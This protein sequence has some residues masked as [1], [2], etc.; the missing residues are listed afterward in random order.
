MSSGAGIIAA[1]LR[2]SFEHGRVPALR[3]VSFTVAPG[4]LVA[5]TGSS[6]SGK[7]TLLNLI[8]A[9]D[10]PDAGSLS[11][12]GRRLDELESHADYRAGTIGFVF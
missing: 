9:L 11:V 5:L 2:K 4:E 12:D 10:T 6:G 3:N 1:G 8:G 7:S